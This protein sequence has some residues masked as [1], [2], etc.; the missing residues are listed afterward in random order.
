MHAIKQAAQGLRHA[1]ARSV[2]QN[3][4]EAVGEIFRQDGFDARQS[5][6]GGEGALDASPGFDEASAKHQR[7]EFFGRKHQRRQIEFAAQRVANAGFAFDGLAGKLEIANVA[8]DSALGDLK[9]LGECA[10]GLQATGAKH[11]HDAKE[12]V[13]PPH[14]PA[15]RLKHGAVQANVVALRVLQAGEVAEAAGDLRA[16]YEDGRTELLSA[17]EAGV[18]LALG[19]EVDERTVGG[20]LLVRAVNDAAAHTAI[21]RGKHVAGFRAREGP[22][23]YIQQR[24]DKLGGP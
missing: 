22:Q 9:A 16:R 18:Q 15:L 21:L 13:G 4:V 24:L 10:S 1:I 6:S 20:G 14:A 19:V 7:G 23:L 12:T 2:H 5:S 3:G 17:L 11:L 8:I